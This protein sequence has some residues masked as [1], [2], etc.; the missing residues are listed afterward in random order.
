MKKI[1]LF[2]VMAALVFGGVK[3]LQNKQNEL[4]NAPTAQKPIFSVAVVSAQEK[5]LKQTTSFLAK[6]ESYNAPKIT[7]KISGFI[8]AIHVKENQMVKKGDLLVEIDSEELQNS[9]TQIQNSIKSI[10]ISIESMETN[11]FSLKSDLKASKNRLSRS[12]ILFNTG[13]LAKEKYELSQVEYE[14]KKAK[15]AST[16]KS[17]ESKKYELAAIKNSYNTK[18][19]NLKYYNIKAP[20]DAIINKVILRDGDMAFAGKTILTL[21]DK[22]Q[23]ITFLFANSDITKGLEVSINETVKAKISKIMKSSDNYLRIAQVDLNTPLD[24]PVESLVNIQVTTKN[25]TG[26]TLPANTVL[27]KNDGNYVVIYGNNAFK[28]KKIEILAQD[29]EHVLIAE[30]INQKVALASESKLAILPSSDNYI[31]VKK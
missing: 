8:Q 12:K 23:K 13:G 20:F 16:L 25:L 5:T 15:L 24:M 1:I 17:I 11:I 26:L 31:I 21:L 2:L 14:L 6:L 27:H 29:E 28:F 9:L 18:K 7:T 22:K 4:T 10:E 3:L 19:A 30:N